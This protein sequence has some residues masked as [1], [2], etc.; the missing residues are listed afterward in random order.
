M[1]HKY[2]RVFP[3]SLWQRVYEIIRRKTD[4]N[5][6][7]QSKVAVLIFFTE[8]LT[9]WWAKCSLISS[10]CTKTLTGKR[11]VTSYHGKRRMNINKLDCWVG[12]TSQMTTIHRHPRTA[13]LVDDQNQTVDKVNG[14]LDTI[15]C[16]L[17]TR[18]QTWSSETTWLA[19]KYDVSISQ[20]TSRTTDQP[21]MLWIGSEF[22]D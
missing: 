20:S 22:T 14:Q 8:E 3:F 18:L 1:L 4:R 13:A 6:T 5:N 19:D 16:Q 12:W 11:L 9:D 17:T 21:P 7:V 10:L 2:T 15:H